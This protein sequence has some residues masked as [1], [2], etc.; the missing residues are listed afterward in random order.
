MGEAKCYLHFDNNK[1]L[2]SKGFI[3]KKPSATTFLLNR[4]VVW[5]AIVSG[6]KKNSIIPSNMPAR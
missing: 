3:P 2:L 4:T 1:A 5:G 6:T